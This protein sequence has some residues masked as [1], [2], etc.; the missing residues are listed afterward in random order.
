MTPHLD[1][2]AAITAGLVPAQ[3]SLADA[4]SFSS[5]EDSPELPLAEQIRRTQERLRESIRDAGAL[6]E[7][8]QALIER[9]RAMRE[10]S[11]RRRESD[12]EYA[13]LA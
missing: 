9:L 7:K 11:K 2:N 6:L 8:T 10:A 1:P 13:P 4:A 3:P 5:E 12:D